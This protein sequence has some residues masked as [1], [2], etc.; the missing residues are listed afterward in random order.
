LLFFL[1]IGDKVVNAVQLVV[2]FSISC[3][4]LTISKGKIFICLFH[5]VFKKPLISGVL[6]AHAYNP[7]CSGG[8]DQE[9]CSSEPAW[10]SSLRNPIWKNP[11]HKK[12]D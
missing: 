2:S 10:A 5:E 6:V 12:N 1:C 4:V 8:R 7:S 11:S 9:S 3:A